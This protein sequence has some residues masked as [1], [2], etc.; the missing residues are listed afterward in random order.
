MA[1]SL[2]AAVVSS[3]VMA[4][5]RN[6]IW[7]AA[8]A[9]PHPAPVAVWAWARAIPGSPPAAFWASPWARRFFPG[10]AAAGSGVAGT[11]AILVDSPQISVASEAVVRAGTV[12]PEVSRWAR[13]VV[14]G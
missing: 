1:G 11:R 7:A 9:T 4:A 5:V 12:V 8:P 10:R 3:P 14:L 13:V 2:V 6:Q